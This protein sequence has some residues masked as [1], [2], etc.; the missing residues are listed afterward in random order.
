MTVFEFERQAQSER[1]TH[2]EF[3]LHGN[4][5]AVGIHDFTHKREPKASAGLVGVLTMGHTVEFLKDT[6]HI[7][8]CD[9]ITL[10]CHFDQK[11]VSVCPHGDKYLSTGRAVLD[12]IGNDVCD[13]LSDQI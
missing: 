6:L 1:R 13:C 9:S 7:L 4:I 12:S 5:T 8:G 2:A 11:I 3:A 10:V